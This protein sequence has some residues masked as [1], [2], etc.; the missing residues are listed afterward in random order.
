[1]MR[2]CERYPTLSSAVCRFPT[3]AIPTLGHPP[4]SAN[5]CYD[6]GAPSSYYLQHLNVT[7]IRLCTYAAEWSIKICALRSIRSSSYMPLRCT[8][9]FYLEVGSVLI[10][11]TLTRDGSAKYGMRTR[12]ICSLSVS[13][14]RHPD[15]WAPTPERKRLL[16]R[17]RAV[18]LFVRHVKQPILFGLSTDYLQHLNVTHIQCRDLCTYAAEW[19]IKAA[20]MP[21]LP[22]SASLEWKYEGGGSGIPCDLDDMPMQTPRPPSDFDPKICPGVCTHPVTTLA[23]L[24][25]LSFIF[26]TS[27]C[28]I[29]TTISAGLHA[30]APTT[31]LRTSSS[32]ACALVALP[33]SSTPQTHEIFRFRRD[34]CESSTSLSRVY[35]LSSLGDGYRL[36]ALVALPGHRQ[37]RRLTLQRRSDRLSTF[38][39]LARTLLAPPV[40]AS[41]ACFAPLSLIPTVHG[42][43]CRVNLVSPW[44]GHLARYWLDYLCAHRLVS[45]RTSSRSRSLASSTWGVS[46]AAMLTC[47]HK[48][49][50]AAMEME[51]GYGEASRRSILAHERAQMLD[52][53]ALAIGAR[54]A[55]AF[56]CA[57]SP[58]TDNPFHRPSPPRPVPPLFGG[59]SAALDEHTTLYPPPAGPSSSEPA[60]HPPHSPAA[61]P[62]LPAF[63]VRAPFAIHDAIVCPALV[64]CLLLVADS[65]I[66]LAW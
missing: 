54:A 56:G 10:A 57:R 50:Y 14:L 33:P 39:L 30:P 31:P 4:P 42:H 58:H 65:S 2:V 44:S 1:M 64:G 19:S 36:L 37:P 12:R 6:A 24:V 38:R 9:C 43:S 41:I 60:P 34:P 46:Y 61:R 59:P 35:D 15:A 62:R 47:R 18:I 20:V 48:Y 51:A 27:S 32:C 3:F 53:E 23:A 26:G 13:H 8:S 66:S 7:H 28:S 5:A 11:A 29:S 52:M 17:G 45:P 55:R 22:A 40:A 49:S 25:P 16:R 21:C 63:L